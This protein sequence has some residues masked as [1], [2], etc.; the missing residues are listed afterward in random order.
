[1]KT[2]FLLI[3]GA[4][5]LLAGARA[6]MA[7]DSSPDSRPGFTS[8]QVIDVNNIFN[9]Y[10]RPPVRGRTGPPPPRIYYFTLNGAMAGGFGNKAYAFFDGTGVYRGKVFTPSDSINGYKIVEIANNTVKLAAASNQFIT[11]KVGMQMRKEDN[12]P[13]KLVASSMPASEYTPSDSGGS[14]SGAQSSSDGSGAD[15]ET[16]TPT[17]SIPGADS[18]VIKRLMK[19]RAEENGDT[20]SAT[21]NTD[22]NQ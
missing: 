19:R 14:D 16:A 6:V 7:Q 4:V 9:P 5:L 1:M 10:R 3:A 13:W 17:P 22:Q 18:D 21:S 8:F 2:S 20:N 12:G 15:A 11:L